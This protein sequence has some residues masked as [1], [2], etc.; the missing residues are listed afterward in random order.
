MF[1]PYQ[2]FGNTCITILEVYNYES[3]SFAI[4]L[5]SADFRSFA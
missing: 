3:L 5:T 2:N 1:S 4:S